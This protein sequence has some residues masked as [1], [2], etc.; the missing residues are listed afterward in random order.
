[1]KKTIAIMVLMAVILTVIWYYKENKHNPVGMNE[2]TE[3][4]IQLVDR[5]MEQMTLEEKVGQMLMPDLRMWEGSNTTEMNPGTIKLIQD[6]HLGGVILFSKNIVNREQLIRLTSAL[7]EVSGDTPLL[8]AIDQEGGS[9]SRI[10]NGTNM[11]GNMALGAT[12]SDELAYQVGYIIGRE[13]KALGINLNFA[14]VMDVNINPANP[15]IGIRSF[16]DDPGLVADLGVQYARG[17]QEA[18]VGAVPK[19]FPGHGDTDVDSHLGLPSIPHDLDRLE[20]VELKPFREAVANGVDMIMTAHV[21]FPAV[22]ESS[23]PATLSYP[24]LTG[25]LRQDMGFEGVIVTDAFTMKAIAEHFGEGEAVVTAI[26]AG[27]DLILM[28]NDIALAYQSILEAVAS[29]ELSHDRINQSVRRILVFKEKYGLLRHEDKNISAAIESA[30]KLIGCPEHRLIEQKVAEK[31]VTLVAN[32]NQVVPF[33]PEGGE[34]ILLLAPKQ[35]QL[36]LMAGAV[37]EVFAHEERKVSLE[38]VVYDDLANLS[39]DVDSDYIIL[40]IENLKEDTTLPF[41]TGKL[42]VMG[43]GTPYDTQYLPGVAYLAVY[44]AEYPNLLAGMKA[45]FGVMEPSGQL[46]VNI[47]E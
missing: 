22:D 6:Y 4:E 16:G 18:G 14:P 2:P 13:L 9:V 10:P 15:V 23:L 46:P 37:G 36:E 20:A 30:Q 45:V 1:M 7:Q 24:V 32:P 28:P 27:A 12:G 3:Q 11:P 34:K 38:K 39:S 41:D 26:K 40:A 19:H 47:P 17:L 21:T 35:N 44:G 5:I 43:L 33:K 42:V 25:L 8:I 29:G 31:A